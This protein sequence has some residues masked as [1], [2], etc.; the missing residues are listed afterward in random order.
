MSISRLA[1]FRVRFI[2]KRKHSPFEHHDL[3]LNACIRNMT[4]MRKGGNAPSVC[5]HY[6]DVLLLGM[7]IDEQYRESTM[8]S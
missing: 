6:M 3:Y 4:S 8:C 5:L 7:L 1:L 2:G